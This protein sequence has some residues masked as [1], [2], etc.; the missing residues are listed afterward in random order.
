MGFVAA[1]LELARQTA[2][3]GSPP[4]DFL[5]LSG[6]TLGMATGLALG[7]RAA[8]L[9]T[10]IVAPRAV[11]SGTGA[12]EHAASQVLEANR[13][14][15]ARDPSF[16]LFDDPLANLELRPEFYGPGYAEPTPGALEAIA[17]LREH[18]IGLDITYTAKAFAG[19][20]ADA[21]WRLFCH[22]SEPAHV[23]GAHL[24]AI[25]AAG[26]CGAVLAPVLCAT[27][28]AP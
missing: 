16:P 19:L 28:E 25:I 8:G 13:E 9:P 22:F 5:Y 20:M 3:A 27:R 21:G 23:L 4:P 10:R 15:R 7:L 12:T 11:P 17:L 14:I 18:G 26:L 2:G 6:G 1:A 24:L